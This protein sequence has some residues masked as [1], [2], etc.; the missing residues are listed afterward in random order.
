MIKKIV[1][2]LSFIIIAGFIISSIVTSNLCQ[3]ETIIDANWT[4]QFGFLIGLTLVLFFWSVFSLAMRVIVKKLYDQTAELKL[5]I[6][7]LEK[8]NN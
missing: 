1:T 4:F 5:Q 8:D 2:A 7:K 3:K 6:E